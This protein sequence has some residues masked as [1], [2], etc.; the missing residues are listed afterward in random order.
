MALIESIRKGFREEHGALL[1]ELS[2]NPNLARDSATPN[3]SPQYA[4]PGI[5]AQEKD[6]QSRKILRGL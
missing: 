3:T 4:S 2:A 6:L 1:I 5:D